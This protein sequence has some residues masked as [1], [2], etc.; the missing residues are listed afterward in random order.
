M[1]NPSWL[2][3][4][5]PGLHMLWEYRNNPKAEPRPAAKRA[6]RARLTAGR[7]STSPL[8][9]RGLKHERAIQRFSKGHASPTAKLMDSRE[10]HKQ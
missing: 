8:V 4:R 1:Q 10:E 5:V 9:A 2:L 3:K 7:D 6:A